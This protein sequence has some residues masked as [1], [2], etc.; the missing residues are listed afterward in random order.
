VTEANVMDAIQGLDRDVTIL[1]VAHRI[2]TLK[3]CDSIVELTNSTISWRGTYEELI[4]RLA[5]SSSNKTIE[6]VDYELG[7]KHT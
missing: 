2:N 7:K 6:V 3:Y 5:N 1:M 4:D